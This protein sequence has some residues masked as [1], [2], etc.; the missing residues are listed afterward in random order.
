MNTSDFD[1]FLPPELIAQKSI[2]PRDHS[3]LMVIDKQAH[4][5]E[6]RLFF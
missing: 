4:S 2:E 3:K 5:I 6:D 1:Y